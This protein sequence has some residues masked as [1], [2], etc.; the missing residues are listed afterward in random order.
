M[1]DAKEL[2][3]LSEAP[4]SADALPE[5]TLL[6]N[7]YLIEEFLSFAGNGFYYVAKDSHLDRSVVVQ[8]FFLQGSKR[9]AE[10]QNVVNQ[11][12]TFKADLAAFVETAKKRI[13]LN[14]HPHLLT[15]LD[16]FTENDTAYVVYAAI[17]GLTLNDFLEGQLQEKVPSEMANKI[18]RQIISAIHAL[19]QSGIIHANINPESVFLTRD[20][21]VKL[22]YDEPFGNDVYLAPEVSGSK[23][24]K[25]NEQT[26]VFSVAALYYRLLTGV[27]PPKIE[28]AKVQVP[29]TS[30][31]E[32]SPEVQHAIRHGMEFKSG[33]RWS[34]VQHF[35]ESL[36]LFVA[37]S[38]SAAARNLET[39]ATQSQIIRV[40]P[41]P[42]FKQR[43]NQIL[44]GITA[45]SALGFL[46]SFLA[47]RSSRGDLQDEIERLQK[48]NN[49][50]IQEYEA[51][52]K[53]ADEAKYAVEKRYQ[54]IIAENGRDIVGMFRQLAPMVTPQ[55]WNQDMTTLP[56]DNPI[57]EGRTDPNSPDNA[58]RKF[59]TVPGKFF[60]YFLVL[61]DGDE[62]TEGSIIKGKDWEYK[63][64]EMVHGY[65]KSKYIIHK[66]L[67]NLWYLG[68]SYSKEIKRTAEVLE[69][70]GQPSDFSYFE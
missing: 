48:A 45:L 18:L 23:K 11:A 2:L 55:V 7:R 39:D 22:G 67:E 20:G 3:N 15:A 31:T 30:E 56:W 24:R 69:G 4:K 52:V 32:V 8:E 53:I 9:A 49:Q 14:E 64:W 60:H 38:T 5:Q 58:G 37:G 65:G 41:Q 63:E 10:S 1:Q 13:Q 54:A 42:W 26:D 27:H 35:Q 12:A 47:F 16:F 70:E 44:L 62:V 68:N 17:E 19:N 21:Q 59:V 25:L 33:N 29:F 43:A 50:T 66:D 28:N 40:L 57:P 61:K 36:G 34:N 6:H 51:K 46:G